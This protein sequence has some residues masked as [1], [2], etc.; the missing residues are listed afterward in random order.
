MNISIKRFPG[1][2]NKFYMKVQGV[3]DNDCNIVQSVVRYL[4]AFKAMV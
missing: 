4:P 1:F 3:N 2:K